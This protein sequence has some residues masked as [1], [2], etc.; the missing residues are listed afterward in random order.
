MTASALAADRE[1]A[2]AAGMNDHV[3]KPLDIEQMFQTLR[4]WLGP[5]IA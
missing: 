4:R 5:P 3:P 1:Q 2:L